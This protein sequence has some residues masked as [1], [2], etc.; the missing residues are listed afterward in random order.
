[1]LST[2]TH[3]QNDVAERKHRHIVELGLTFLSQAS[4]A[5]SY[6]KELCLPNC[7]VAHQ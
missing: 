4:L 6:W 2:H 5:L 7:Y 3:R 1:M